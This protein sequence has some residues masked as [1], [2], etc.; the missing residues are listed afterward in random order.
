MGDDGGYTAFK[1]R[2]YEATTFSVALSAAGYF[3]FMPNPRGSYGAG[4]AFTRANV[5]DFGYGDFRDIMT[6]V[7][8]A[9]KEAPIDAVAPGWTGWAVAGGAGY[10]E[11]NYR[12]NENGN[13]VSYGN[14]PSDYL[15]DVLAGQA[16]R[17]IRERAGQP[18]FI[19]IATFAPHAPYVPAPRDAEALAGVHA[20]RTP[21]FNAAPEPDMPKWLLG[22]EAPSEIDMANIDRDFRKRAQSVLAVDKMIAD[23]MAAVA[24]I[25]EEKNTY[26]VF[27]SDNGYHMGEHRL[28]PGKM[29]AFDTDI[30]VP[31]IL[32]GPGVV[33]GQTIDAIALNIDLYSTFTELGGAA[34]AANV[35]GHSLA[36]LL[37]GEPVSEWRSLALIEHRGPHRDRNDPDAPGQRSSNPPTYEAIRGGTFLYVEYSVGMNE[38]HDLTRDP[39]E[40]HNGYAGLSAKEQASFGAALAA[41][42]SCHGAEHCWKAERLN[43]EQLG[44]ATAR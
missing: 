15:T 7:D 17:F 5:K 11:F 26:F 12:L 22:R 16:A 29:T 18:F 24:A 8:Q 28:M 39:Y 6:G 14:Q 4:E 37:R 3:V 41:A 9:L 27:S 13:P 40:L 30:R 1:T 10:R 19:E 43:R 32:T 34:A 42:K 20:P 35:D 44:A 31:L 33:A 25:G 21:A 36:P 23:L 2:G 38:Y